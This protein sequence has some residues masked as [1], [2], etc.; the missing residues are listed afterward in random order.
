MELIKKYKDVPVFVDNDSIYETN[1][2]GRRLLN[3]F[4]IPFLNSL[5]GNSQFL[6]KRSHKQ[7]EEVIENA[8]T[9]AAVEIL[10]HH[11]HPHKSKRIVC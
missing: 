6:I 2:F 1:S 11:G 9:H 10:Y 4:W 5:P 3:F 7:A 8:T